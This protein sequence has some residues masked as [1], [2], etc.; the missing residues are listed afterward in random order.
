MRKTIVLILC[1]ALLPLALWAQTASQFMTDATLVSLSQ[2]KKTVTLRC[3]GMAEKKKEAVV[4]AQKSALYNLLHLGVDGVNGGQ[5]LCPVADQAYDRRM[6]SENR[7]MSFMASCVDLDNY[8]KMGNKVKAEVEVTFYLQ[9]LQRDLGRGQSG[10][11]TPSAGKNLPS[12][13][14]VPFIAQSENQLEVL[15]GNNVRRSAASSVTAMFS[16]KGYL[17]KDYL[18]M[19]RNMQND[20]IL[21]SGT[22]SDAVTKM[23]QN[24]GTDVKVEVRCQCTQGAMNLVNA[25]VEI[26]AVEAFT[27]TTL[28]SVTLSGQTRGDTTMAVTQ[29]LESSSN[30]QKRNTFFQ[31]LNKSFHAISVQGVEVS[32]SM[33]IDENVDDFTFEDELADGSIFKEALEEWLQQVAVDENARIDMSNDKYLGIT[34]RVPFYNDKGKTY[35]VS[36]FRSALRKKLKELLGEDHVATIDAM[37]QKLSVKIK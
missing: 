9:S 36:G 13:T 10:S 37:G 17:T 32:L 21:L 26:K 3:S 18:A 4:M 8:T 34:L 22:Q 28:A 12:I 2:D 19:L 35:K 14:I 25:I 27:S 11:G 7:Y 23:L 6:F 5:P 29:I 30:T 31:E 16:K 20:D 1:L 33:A 24:A 15:E